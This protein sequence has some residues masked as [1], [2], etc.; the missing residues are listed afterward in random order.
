MRIEHVIDVHAF[1]TS[2]WGTLVCQ[3]RIKVVP[4]HVHVYRRQVV[5]VAL[6]M[7]D[8]VYYLQ[9]SCAL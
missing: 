8:E 7:S 9:C 6:A 5:V 1:I 4:A 3:M 2:C